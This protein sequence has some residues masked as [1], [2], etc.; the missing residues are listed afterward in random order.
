MTTLAQLDYT[1]EGQ[2]F[3]LDIDQQLR[4][5]LKLFHKK[6][7][8]G[9]EEN[10]RWNYHIHVHLKHM[11]DALNHLDTIKIHVPDV[12]WDIDSVQWCPYC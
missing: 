8:K 7:E 12:D 1:E 10:R 2:R 5:Q 4:W 11:K 3:T 9:N 6:Q